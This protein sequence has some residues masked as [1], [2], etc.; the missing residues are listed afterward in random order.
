LQ[1]A[2]QRLAWNRKQLKI[3]RQLTEQYTTWSKKLMNSF[4][5]QLQ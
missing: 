3:Q 2:H 4:W 5:T 1:I